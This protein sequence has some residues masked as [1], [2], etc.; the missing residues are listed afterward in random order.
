MS[1]EL[2]LLWQEAT[3]SELDPEEVA[4]LAGR[5]TVA[6]FDSRIAM[7]NV[8]E[9]GASALVLLAAGVMLIWTK[10]RIF[11]L[12]LVAGVTFVV[13]YLWTKHRSLTPLDPSADA[14]SY[15]AAMLTRIDQQMGLLSSIRYWYL[16]PLYIPALWQ[17]AS[18]WR[19]SPAAAIFVWV[20]VTA[21]F[22]WV[23]RL[24]ER[25]GITRLK[26]E[27]EKLE[28]LYKDEN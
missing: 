2:M 16:L 17:V 8:R 27:R 24:N 26:A 7:R 20:T 21:S 25:I 18:T 13:V 11:P 5:A 6:R 14:K 3:Q 22:A 19:R 15:R 23:A 9:Y 1:D 12:L 4:R 10:E 28:A